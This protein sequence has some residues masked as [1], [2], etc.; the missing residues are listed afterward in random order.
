MKKKAIRAELRKESKTFPG[1]FKY[2]LDVQHEDGIIE[3]NVPAYG[4]D[5]QDALSRTV[6]QEKV[7][8][9]ENTLSSLPNWV[10]L[11]SWFLYLLGISTGFVLTNDA[12]WMI[13]GLMFPFIAFL[14]VHFWSN[15]KTQKNG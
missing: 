12:S 5:L 8:K 7:E 2:E 3:K 13:G 14:G 1:Y 6:K 4:K 15:Y 10:I 11:M 9:I